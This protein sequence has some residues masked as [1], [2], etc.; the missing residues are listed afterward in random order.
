ML[1]GIFRKIIGKGDDSS[2]DVAKKRL[3]FA[4]VY[5]RLDV[6]DD[7]L[8]NLQRDIVEVISR[9]FE[10]DKDGLSLDIRDSG[11]LSALVL[12]TPILSKR[13]DTS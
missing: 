10:I 13:R 8:E 9:Y 2:K 12:N 1:N 3:K 11:D 7:V 5:D 6:S 4:L